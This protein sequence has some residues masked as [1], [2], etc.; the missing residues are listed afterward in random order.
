MGDLSIFTSRFS[1]NSKSLREFDEALR[2]FKDGKDV[3]RNLESKRA[4]NKLLTVIDPIV[5][6]LRD[7][8]TKSVA[9]NERG[10]VKIIM[11]R[12]S[13]EWPIYKDRIE[14]LHD[15][16]NSD[17]FSLTKQDF[18]LLNDIAD[19]LDSECAH[20]FRRISEKT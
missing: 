10:V 2:Y 8:I 5:E 14:K 3:Q 7:S 11:N 12:H 4:I 6:S 20:L 15:K 1:I 18:R 16:L 13:K 17:K 19:A 9:I